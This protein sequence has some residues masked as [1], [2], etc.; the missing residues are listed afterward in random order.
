MREKEREESKKNMKNTR[1]K[2]NKTQK[3]NNV[4]S[5]SSYH[6]CFANTCRSKYK[7]GAR[8]Q[9]NNSKSKRSRNKICRSKPK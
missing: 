8:K 2:N 3:R 1:E 6:S 4:N 7:L 5:S 9:W